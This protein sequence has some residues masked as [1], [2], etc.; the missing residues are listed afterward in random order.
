MKLYVNVKQVGSRKNF[1]AKEEII[2][3]TIPGTLKELIEN[4]VTKN[5]QEFN[6]NL[7]KERL[8]DYLTSEEIEGKANQGKVSF[9]TI[10]NESKEDLCKAIDTAL[11]AFE[12][13]LYKVFIGDDE[14]E[15]LD[16][17]LIAKNEDVLTFI[18]LTMLSGR[19]W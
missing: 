5:V 17:P 8:V 7:K 3:E 4:I 16:S 6:E 14:I 15:Y 12:D 1:I 9:G 10:Y 2:L 19:L 18:K 13:G 11:L